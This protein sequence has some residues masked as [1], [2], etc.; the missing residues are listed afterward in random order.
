[1]SIPERGVSPERLHG[2][3]DIDEATRQLELA[4]HDIA[5]ASS[6]IGLGDLNEAHT[7]VITARVAADAAEEILRVAI[8]SGGSG[9]P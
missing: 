1:M 7:N 4:A 2:P 6:C 8:M 9:L 5:V 3:V